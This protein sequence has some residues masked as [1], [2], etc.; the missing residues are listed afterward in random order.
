MTDSTLIASIVIEG[1]LCRDM[2]DEHPG[3]AY[4][5]TNARRGVTIPHHVPLATAKAIAEAEWKLCHPETANHDDWEEYDGLFTPVRVLLLARDRTTIQCFEND[6]WVSS[7]VPPEQWPAL[8]SQAAELE[9]EASIEA[10]WDNF[11]TAERHRESASAIRRTVAIARA[12]VSSQHADRIRGLTER[13]QLA[14]ARIATLADIET[15]TPGWGS[16]RCA[17]SALGIS[18]HLAGILEPPIMFDGEPYL[19]KAWQE[20]VTWAEE[21]TSR[22]EAVED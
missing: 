19:L 16:V 14:M 15:E 10:G 7:F 2:Y 4:F 18:E 20:G 8:L 17:A 21:F 12:N 22:N 13:V 6:H 1:S 9:S 5:Y 11:S 3:L